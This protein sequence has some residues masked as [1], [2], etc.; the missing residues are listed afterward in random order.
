MTPIRT[1]FCV[2]L[3]I[4]LGACAH[5]PNIRYFT[6]DDGRPAAMQSNSGPSVAIVQVNLPDLIDRP[7]L[8]V[9]THGHQVKINDMYAWAEP[10]RQQ[11]PRLLAKR[12]G[13]ELD[14][15]N[16]ISLPIDAQDYD[17]D[18]YVTLDIQRLDVI[19]GE[20]VNLDV[21]WRVVSREGEALTGRCMVSEPLVTSESENEY[22]R[23]VA[24]QSRAWKNVARQIAGVIANWPG[25]AALGA[26]A[27]D[28]R[29]NAP[30]D[31]SRKGGW[32][33]VV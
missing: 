14:S 12:M 16:V 28:H 19:A 10:L 31:I 24:A 30:L 20:G 1:I 8:V 5:S 2:A 15:F 22:W 23:A 26:P 6:L 4:S 29:M 3:A 13:E 33:H 7:Q 25:D 17:M 18:F 27:T 21:I 32:R 9:R 11:I